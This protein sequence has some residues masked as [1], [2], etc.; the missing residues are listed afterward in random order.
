MLFFHSVTFQEVCSISGNPYTHYFIYKY[1]HTNN[2]EESLPPSPKK[3]FTQVSTLMNILSIEVLDSHFHNFHATAV[4][5]LYTTHIILLQA[6]QKVGVVTL[7]PSDCYDHVICV[8]RLPC[9]RRLMRKLV[10]HLPVVII[11]GFSAD[12][13]LLSP[14]GLH[15]SPFQPHF[16]E[17]N[18]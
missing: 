6:L 2:T 3:K 14:R 17:V 5:G 11:S 13:T 16:H 4:M 18:L 10:F 1:T 15:L 7:T 12:T 9:P 8:L